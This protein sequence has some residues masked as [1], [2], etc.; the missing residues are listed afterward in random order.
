MTQMLAKGGV[1]QGLRRSTEISWRK[2]L[3]RVFQ[4]RQNLKTG[5]VK[6]GHNDKYLENELNAEMDTVVY[7]INFF[8]FWSALA[9]RVFSLWF[10]SSRVL[11]PQ[12][13]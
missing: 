3:N 7:G 13:L 1:A 12:K 5:R 10:Q 6:L 2:L 11:L 4:L 9:F 8:Q